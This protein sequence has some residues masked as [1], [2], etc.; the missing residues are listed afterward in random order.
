MRALPSALLQQPLYSQALLRRSCL[1][2]CACSCLLFTTGLQRAC[3][4]ACLPS[5]TT[6][7]CRCWPACLLASAVSCHALPLLAL[8]LYAHSLLP[9]AFRRLHLHHTSH[10]LKPAA[11]MAALSNSRSCR[12][13]CN[14][15]QLPSTRARHAP[16][17]CS[18]KPVAEGR[19]PAA[20]HA[21]GA[22]TPVRALSTTYGAVFTSR[23]K[24]QRGHD[25]AAAP[26]A[27]RRTAIQPS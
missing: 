3:A 16:S 20:K 21:N 9:H 25:G 12:S 24:R 5:R 1:R 23:R 15:R 2:R 6:C 7:L 22:K 19:A 11:C 4:H 18:A 27:T 26:R 8:L 17:S 10:W 13:Q 14:I